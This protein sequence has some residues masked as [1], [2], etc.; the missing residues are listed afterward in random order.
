MRS[1][2]PHVNGEQELFRRHLPSIEVAYP[3]LELPEGRVLV[4]T[5]PVLLHQF[6]PKPDPNL[7]GP[8]F[9]PNHVPVCE[10]FVCYL[11]KSGTTSGV[12]EQSTRTLS[13]ILAIGKTGIAIAQ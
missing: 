7:G 6:L 12:L 13:V 10:T 8:D 5:Q 1:P 9:E 4:E 11:T 2:V 3:V